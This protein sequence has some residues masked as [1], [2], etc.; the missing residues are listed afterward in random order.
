MEPIT[1]ADAKMQECLDDL[2]DIYEAGHKVIATEWNETTGE[3]FHVYLNEPLDSALKKYF[4][5]YPREIRNFIEDQQLFK[6]TLV[7]SNGMS[8]DKQRRLL[9]RLPA[10]LHKFIESIYPRYMTKEYAKKL[11]ELIPLAF[12]K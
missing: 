2:K 9:H 7:G 11:R 10:N 8:K 6:G 12:T 4:K 1:K 3:M 5:L